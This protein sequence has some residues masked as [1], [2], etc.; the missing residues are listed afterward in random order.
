MSPPSPSP[1]PSLQAWIRPAWFFAGL[2]AGLAVL[3]WCGWRSGRTDYHPGF[4]RVYPAISPETSYYPTVNELAAIVRHR[5]RPDQVLVLIGGNSILEGVWQPVSDLWSRRL[6]ELLG[7]RFCVV[8][9]AFRGGSPTDGAAVVAEVLRREF[10]RQILVVDEAPFNGVDSIAHEPYRYLFWQAYF[11][12]WLEDLPERNRHVAEYQL[13]R[14][15][16]HRFL[17]AAADAW[18][19]RVLHFHDLWNRVCFERL[20]TVPSLLGAS[21]PEL[22]RPRVRFLDEEPDAYDPAF[23][24]SKYPAS[25]LEAE[26]AIVRNLSGQFYRRDRTGAWRFPDAKR[27]ELA[28]SYREAFP[29]DLAARTLVLLGHSS[30]YYVQRLTPEERALYHRGF[31]ESRALW[32]AAGYP[33]LIYGADYTE[34]DFGDR[35]HLSK[36][37]GRKLAEQVGA[38]VGSL[39][40]SLSYLP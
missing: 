11:R 29:P 1:L 18:L 13:D 12:G 35:I 24:A 25:S 23:L 16:R 19:D 5:C 9:L 10:P 21:V 6:Q 40:K 33:A 3:S 7:E 28:R 14:E 37:G 8:N 39:A 15:Q 38:E 27:R 32:R 4:Q 30:P 26:M 36:T 31:E 34:D 20:C 17:E 22:L 2:L